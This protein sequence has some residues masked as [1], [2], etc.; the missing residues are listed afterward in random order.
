MF[1]LRRDWLL[2]LVYTIII[3][4]IDI[5]QYSTRMDTETYPYSIWSLSAPA[6][7]EDQ[8]LPGHGRDYPQGPARAQPQPHVQSLQGIPSNLSALLLDAF[9]FSVLFIHSVKYYSQSLCVLVQN[10][11]YNLH[12][13][14]IH[15]RFQLI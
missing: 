5:I 3:I 12:C 4:R 10:Y 14:L 15:S 8:P 7:A 13:V 11:E 9:A 6:P 2:I 1:N